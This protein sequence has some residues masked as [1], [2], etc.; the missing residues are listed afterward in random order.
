M[1]LLLYKGV[2]GIAL[3]ASKNGT[4]LLFQWANLGLFLFV[5]V[6]TTANINYNQCKIL[7]MTG[8]EPRISGIGSDR[9]ANWATTTGT[10]LITLEKTIKQWI[11]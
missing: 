5:F 6:F 10:Q 7:P 9:S 2:L 3:L 11:L 4:Q 1:G 8:F